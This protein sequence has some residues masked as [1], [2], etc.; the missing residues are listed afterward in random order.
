MSEPKQKSDTSDIRRTVLHAPSDY[1]DKQ[2]I[3][4]ITPLA[5]VPNRLRLTTASWE[6]AST[7]SR[8]LSGS[9]GTKHKA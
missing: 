4:H 3:E 1:A 9:H 2:A 6:D 7:L 8:I 5:A